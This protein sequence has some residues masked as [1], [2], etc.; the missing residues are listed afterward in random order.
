MLL[1]GSSY[2]CHKPVVQVQ[3]TAF[4]CRHPDWFAQCIE[5]SGEYRLPL[6]FGGDIVG[7]HGYRQYTVVLQY[8]MKGTFKILPL[9]GGGDQNA[10]WAGPRP[11]L[12]ERGESCL[13]LWCR[14]LHNQVPD[15]AANYLRER[16]IKDL[17]EC[18]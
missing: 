15:N 12:Q 2:H 10:D 9:P 3:K 17:Y 7:D 16:P 11:L 14:G 18:L 1:G 8:R 4:V 13:Q 6:A 5:E